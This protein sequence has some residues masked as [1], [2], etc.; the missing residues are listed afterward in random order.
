MGWREK[1]K[2]EG[3][4]ELSWK[5]L[6]I[7]SSVNVLSRLMILFQHKILKTVFKRV[8]AMLRFSL[9]LKICLLL[10]CDIVERVESWCAVIVG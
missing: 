8:F 2:E 7:G 3:K 9:E 10:S 5:V 6:I 1:G 4:K